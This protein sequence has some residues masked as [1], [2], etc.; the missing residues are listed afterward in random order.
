MYKLKG[1][2]EFQ[3]E[4][5]MIWVAIM[6]DYNSL[7]VNQQVSLSTEGTNFGEVPKNAYLLEEEYLEDL[8]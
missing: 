1:D 3:D 7:S 8:E 5:L 6:F 2:E 4:G